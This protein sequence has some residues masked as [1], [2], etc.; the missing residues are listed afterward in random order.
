MVRSRRGWRW[1]RRSHGRCWNWLGPDVRTLMFI[2][3][4]DISMTNRLQSQRRSVAYSMMLMGVDTNMMRMRMRMGMG[5]WGMVVHYVMVLMMRMM[6]M[7][8]VT[9]H[10]WHTVGLVHGCCLFCFSFPSTIDGSDRKW[11]QATATREIAELAVSFRRKQLQCAVL[12]GTTR[13]R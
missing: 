6:L 8:V 10:W 1:G 13:R 11:Q 12:G 5:S 3:I 4:L 9:I 2:H 7:W